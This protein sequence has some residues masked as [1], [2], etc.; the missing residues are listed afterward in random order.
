MI[1]LFYWLFK[2]Q[3][4]KLQYHEQSKKAGFEK[5]TFTFLDSNG[6]RYYRYTNDLDIPIL[7]KGE[8]ERVLMEI[9]SGLSGSELSNILEAMGNAINERKGDKMTPNISKIGFL[10]EEI[11]NRKEM[12]LHPDL[13]FEAVAILYIREDEDPA[14]VDTEIL[15]EKVKQLKLNSREGLYDFFYTSGLG[16]YIPFLGKSEEEWMEY[17]EQGR[18][19]LEAMKTYLSTSVQE[20]ST[21]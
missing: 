10:I 7:R 1:R 13:L 19:K 6:K 17:Y 5:L 18:V 8:L 15:R 11:K 21:T 16:A 12:L 20:S 9:E 3:I 4:L 14:I 2:S